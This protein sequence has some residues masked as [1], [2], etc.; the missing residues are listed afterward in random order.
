MDYE[1]VLQKLIRRRDQTIGMIVNDPGRIPAHAKE[2]A[3]IQSGIDVITSLMKPLV[4]AVPTKAPS[5]SKEKK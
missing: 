3:D 1:L 2:L 4:E 5:K